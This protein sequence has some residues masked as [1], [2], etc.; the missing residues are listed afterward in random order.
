[1]VYLVHVQHPFNNYVYPAGAGL[2]TAA[3]AAS[4]VVESVKKAQAEVSAKILQ[5]AIS[6]CK[7]N[8]VRAETLIFQGDSKDEICKAA[9]QTHVD[10]LI[11]GS[12]GLGGIKRKSMNFLMVAF[13]GSVSDYCA[14]HAC[15]PVLI[16]KPPK[17]IK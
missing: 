11:I 2:H 17:H 12:R 13:L 8:M 7:Q 9:E 16:V 6:I 15:C 14:H 4:S 10:M 3:F 1:M 5:R